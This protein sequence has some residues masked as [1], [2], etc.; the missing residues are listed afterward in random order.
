MRREKGHMPCQILPKTGANRPP[1]ISACRFPALVG[2]LT[3]DF[4]V[5]GPNDPRRAHG[6]S[7][8]GLFV[9]KS[10]R[11]KGVVHAVAARRRNESPQPASARLAQAPTAAQ[12]RELLHRQSTSGAAVG[13]GL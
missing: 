4:E 1:L 12:Q 8:V 2:T 6:Q 10:S 11:P 9:R 3:T 13:D 5:N 7:F